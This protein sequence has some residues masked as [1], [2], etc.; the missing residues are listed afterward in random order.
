MSEIK[1]FWRYGVQCVGIKKRCR[2]PDFHSSGRELEV[3]TDQPNSDLAVKLANEWLAANMK[4]Y[5][6]PVATITFWK[7]DGPCESWE[8]FTEAHNIK[9]PLEA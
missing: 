4:S 6:K 3:K 5:R 8:P 7:V 2:K 1:T 9:I